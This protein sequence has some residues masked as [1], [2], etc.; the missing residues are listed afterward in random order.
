LKLDGLLVALSVAATAVAGFG[1]VYGEITI[2]EA[3]PYDD[4]LEALPFV[5]GLA[6]LPFV[7]PALWCSVV[8][9]QTG[10]SRPRTAAWLLLLAI[11]LGGPFWLLGALVVLTGG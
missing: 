4:G 5:V 7:V 6:A 11:L 1:I 9:L 3:G 8:A 2:R 10:R